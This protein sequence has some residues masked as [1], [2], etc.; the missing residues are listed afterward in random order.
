MYIIFMFE[1]LTKEFFA[2]ITPANLKWKPGI[3]ESLTGAMAHTYRTIRRQTNSRSV[4]SMT[5]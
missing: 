3:S 1:I 4:K 2:H 5:G